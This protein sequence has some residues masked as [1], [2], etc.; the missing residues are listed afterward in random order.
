[1]NDVDAVRSQHLRQL[2]RMQQCSETGR[3]VMTGDRPAWQLVSNSLDSWRE[4]KD[5]FVFDFRDNGRAYQEFEYRGRRRRG[6]VQSA[7]T[8]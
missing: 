5:A 2:S 6:H 3:H 7:T 4:A 8:V 1:M